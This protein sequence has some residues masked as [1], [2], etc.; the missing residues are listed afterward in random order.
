[1]I[2]RLLLFLVLFAAVSVNAQRQD[3]H[4]WVNVGVEGEAFNLIDFSIAPELRLSNNSSRVDALLT[5][6]DL[7]V[8]LTNFLRIGVEYRYKIDFE[9]EG[10]SNKNR[11]GVYLELDDKRNGFRYAYRAMYLREYTDIYTT[12]L[13]SLPE[14]MHRHKLSLKYS[15]K[16]WDITPGVSAEGFFTLNPPWD[17]G[18]QKWRFTA[19]VQYRLTKDINLGL[20]YKFQCEFNTNDP[21]SVHILDV[22]LEYEL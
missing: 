11:G 15:Q 19:G 21:L 16:G 1:M 10:K 4:T 9:N 13:G 12:E 5:E 18:R 7:S 22:G 20:G 2:R 14:T 8:P 17:R 3:F 6:I